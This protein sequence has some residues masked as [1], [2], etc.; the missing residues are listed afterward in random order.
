MEIDRLEMETP[1]PAAQQ[2]RDADQILKT[3]LLTKSGD[4]ASER[5]SQ[6]AGI[7]ET[8]KAKQRIREARYGRMRDKDMFEMQK[9]GM[10]VPITAQLAR[11]EE[12]RYKQKLNAF[13]LDKS[14]YANLLNAG[15]ANFIGNQQKK[16]FNR[17][18][19]QIKG[20]NVYVTPPTAH[21]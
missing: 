1:D 19:S 13:N 7:S 16:K 4:R 11:G 2:F 17:S 14:A 15:L 8:N 10:K 6:L 9:V 21:G 5:A 18:L 12:T 3:A 20:S